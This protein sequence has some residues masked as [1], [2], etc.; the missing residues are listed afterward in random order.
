MLMAAEQCVGSVLLFAF[1]SIFG[2][3]FFYYG[4]RK[5]FFK[6]I[7][8]NIPTSKVRSIAMGLVEVVGKAAPVNTIK[9][10]SGIDCIYYSSMIKKGDSMFTLNNGVPFLLK[11]ETGSVLVDPKAALIPLKGSRVGSIGVG[12]DQPKEVADFLRKKGISA[13]DDVSV[14]ESVILPGDKLYVIGTADRNP[15]K[16]P[17]QIVIHKGRNYKVF[18][19][20]AESEKEILLSLN[21]W[22]SFS[23]IAGPASLLFCAFLVVECFAY[24]PF[25]VFPVLGVL[26]VLSGLF[27]ATA[28]S[29]P[30]RMLGAKS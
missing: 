14:L 29:Y 6:R 3:A 27:L 23:M 1:A 26:G 11:D 30:M 15:E 8:E 2:V 24:Q 5:I 28:F 4:L 20:S 16:G 10:L 9:S 21:K 18:H 7:I 12:P 17:V 13:D 19:I 25:Y 22:I